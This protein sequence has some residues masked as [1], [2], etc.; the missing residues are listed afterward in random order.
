M[1]R[2]TEARGDRFHPRRCGSRLG[3]PRQQPRNP[4]RHLWIHGRWRIGEPDLASADHHAPG[5]CQV[6]E[7]GAQRPVVEGQRR[8]SAVRARSGYG[9]GGAR[10]G[11]Q[12]VDPDGAPQRLAPQEPLQRGDQLALGEPPLREVRRMP[13][14]S[15]WSAASLR[16][17]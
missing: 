9:G 7:D 16:C 10:L 5:K 8:R 15:R 12:R 3:E 2:N 11:D 13:R 17:R 1:R 14:L 6:V 4:F